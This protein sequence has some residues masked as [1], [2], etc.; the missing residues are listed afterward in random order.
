ME[1]IIRAESE[2]EEKLLAAK[3]VGYKG[4]DSLFYAVRWKEGGVIEK[5]Q[6]W[7]FGNVSW[8]IGKIYVG[9]KCLERIFHSGAN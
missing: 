8:L 7:S 9:L 3:A 4:V 5:E 1:I 2:A 6:S